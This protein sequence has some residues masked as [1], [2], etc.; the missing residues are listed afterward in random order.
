MT[1]YHHFYYLTNWSLMAT[2]AYFHAPSRAL[3]A[4]ATVVSAMCTVMYWTAIYSPPRHRHR[5]DGRGAFN[6]FVAVNVHGVSCAMLLLDAFAL[7]GGLTYAWR[8]IVGVL[9]FG[10]AWHAFG[11]GIFMNQG[12]WMYTFLAVPKQ[13]ACVYLL[14]PVIFFGFAKLQ[15]VMFG[16]G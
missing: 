16:T 11:I 13:M 7:S 5:E 12:K 3:H 8:D 10:G 2:T 14:L 15:R 4:V 9:V 6:F 1:G